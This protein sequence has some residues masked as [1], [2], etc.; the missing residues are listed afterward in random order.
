MATPALRSLI[1]AAM[2][3]AL[4]G[5][6]EV[7]PTGDRTE[8]RA[9]AGASLKREPSIEAVDEAVPESLF[10]WS[11]YAPTGAPSVQVERGVWICVE[12]GWLPARAG[13]DAGPPGEEDGGSEPDGDGAGDVAPECESSDA[14]P[15][16]PEL[17]EEIAASERRWLEAIAPAL[18][19]GVRV[20]ARLRLASGS[21][22]NVALWRTDAGKLCLAG[23]VGEGE[24]LSWPDD[25]AGMWGP[26][27]GDEDED[28]CAV[29]ICMTWQELSC[30]GEICVGEIEHGGSAVLLGVVSA[31]ADRLE[32]EFRD[33]DTRSYPLRGP[34]VR[35]FPNRRIFMAELG[36]RR[37]RALELFGGDASLARTELP[38]HV[39]GM[40]ECF[41]RAAAEIERV[42]GDTRPDV[43]RIERRLREC[44]GDPLSG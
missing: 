35:E 29:G 18:G 10:G 34:L 40:D 32:V 31:E 19:S 30:P 12:S 41:D 13:D 37:H 17:Q 27:L 4:S 44:I 7:E 20:V 43:E 8:H 6:G 11:A 3:V 38:E 42:D 15:V 21:L 36:E 23:L 5:C 25:G 1:V 14:R 16:S 26:C 24:T 9:A 22:A 33:A 28:D 2:A 39:I